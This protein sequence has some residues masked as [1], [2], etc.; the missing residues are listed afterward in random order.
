M[1]KIA[2][3]ALSMIGL[4][5]RVL[6]ADAPPTAVVMI[7]HTKV[8]AAFAAGGSLLRNSSFKVSAGRRVAPGQVEIHAADTDIFY[9]VEGSATFV[10]GGK[11]IDPKTTGPGEQLADKM[12]GGEA[13]RLTKGD[14]IVIPAGIAHQYTAVDGTFLYF[15][16]KVTR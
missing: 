16:V 8:D 11:A 12:E 10:T 6:A 4:V 15:V 1:K 7:D 9:I 14:V 3:L 5:A 2:L 13:H